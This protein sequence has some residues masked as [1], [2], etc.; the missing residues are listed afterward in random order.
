MKMDGFRE[1]RQQSLS[2][3]HLRGHSFLKQ[4]LNPRYYP[5]CTR[6]LN[7]S[8]HFGTRKSSEAMK[9]YFVHGANQVLQPFAELAPLVI[10]FK[11]RVIMSVIGLQKSV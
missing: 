7:H 11:H 2:L 6:V 10:I 5:Q 4:Y 3:P 9:G 8:V 1:K